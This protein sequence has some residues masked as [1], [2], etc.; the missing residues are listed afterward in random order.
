[1]MFTL[2]LNKALEQELQDLAVQRGRPV[3]Q[4][5]KEMITEYLEDIHDA[6]LGDAAMDELVRGESTTVSFDEVKRQ[7]NELAD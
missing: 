7:L 2:E 4:L 5:L 1:M 6:A 3:S